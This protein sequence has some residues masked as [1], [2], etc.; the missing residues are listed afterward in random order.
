MTK[1]FELSGKSTKATIYAS[2]IDDITIAQI[3]KFIDEDYMKDTKVVIMPDTH[4]GKG[5]VIGTTMHVTDK[6]CPNLV[7]VDIGC[8][9]LVHE[10]QITDF[11]END[12]HKLDRVIRQ[13]VPSGR[14]VHDLEQV[15]EGINQL[16]FI[17][18]RTSRIRQSLGTLGG[19]N[20]FISIEKSLNTGKYYLMIHSGSRSLGTLVA[21]HHQDIAE[22]YCFN[23]PDERQRIIQQFKSENRQTEIADALKHIK[24]K[25]AD[26]DLSY[27]EGNQLT[28]YLNDQ[29]IAVKFAAQNRAAMASAI[30]KHMGYTSVDSF[31]SIH[32]YIDPETNILR[33]GATD[34]SKDMRLVIPLNMKDGS[35]IAKG[36]GNPDFN[37]SAPHGAGRIMSRKQARENVS[38]DDYK[39]DMQGVFTS[40]VNTSTLDESRFAYKSP[41]DIIDNIGETCEIIDRVVTVYNFKASE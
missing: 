8:G 19:G 30:L 33:K 36:L 28:N 40:S 34:A 38:L 7:G 17:P 13:Y 29:A 23:N 2:V 1:P 25:V 37:Y 11:N 14:N 18:K 26:K 3:Q 10:L 15:F 39:D 32:N 35:L 21:N 31:D 6:V 9:I 16:T 4:A 20:H 5:A 27:L 22:Q 41:Q 12:F 24:P